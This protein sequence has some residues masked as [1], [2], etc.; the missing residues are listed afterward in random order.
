MS[1]RRHGQVKDFFIALQN[2][3]PD[4]I[5]DRRSE[6]GESRA[7]DIG[8]DVAVV[9]IVGLD[10]A[11]DDAVLEARLLVRDRDTSGGNSR[12]TCSN[13]MTP[14][15][16]RAPC[17]HRRRARWNVNDFS[18]FLRRL[19]AS[20]ISRTASIPSRGATNVSVP[21]SGVTK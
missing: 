10:V 15:A 6:L 20:S 17:R 2:F 11:V 18:E 12:P 1:S 9:A 14:A 13:V 7:I 8:P 21:L 3:Y 16:S 19:T 5:A 4:L